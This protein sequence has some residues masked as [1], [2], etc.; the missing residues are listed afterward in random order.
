MLSDM[1]F[2]ILAHTNKRFAKNLSKQYKIIFF[3]PTSTICKVIRLVRYSSTFFLSSFCISIFLY[4]S[5]CHL[6]CQYI[7]SIPLLHFYI[8]IPFKAI[9]YIS[10]INNFIISIYL[11]CD[12]VLL[13][14][15]FTTYLVTCN[16]TDE[17]F[18]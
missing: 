2:P 10:F 13:Y 4:N 11:Y 12:F 14:N 9:Y 3:Y 5:I 15:D 16:E 7:L 1:V 18:S 8:F 6:P 17:I